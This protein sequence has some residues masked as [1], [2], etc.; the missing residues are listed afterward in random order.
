MT[1]IK[2][3]PSILQGSGQD[4]QG[5]GQ[6]ISSAGSSVLGAATGAPSYDGQFGPKVAAIGQEAYSRL[7]NSSDQLDNL[8]SRLSLKGAEFQA[9]DMEGESGFAG[10]YPLQLQGEIGGVLTNAA[11]GLN[12]ATS[13]AATRF[14]DVGGVLTDAGQIAWETNLAGQ[15]IS[16]APYLNT[17]AQTAGQ[18][19]LLEEAVKDTITSES[20]SVAIP[21]G[22]LGNLLDWGKDYFEYRD[23]GATMVASA[24]GVDTSISVVGEVGGSMIGGLIGGAIGTF[25]LPVPG[26]GTVAGE[27]LGQ[28]IGGAVGPMA[29]KWAM[30]NIH[31]S[32]AGNESLHDLAIKGVSSVLTVTPVQ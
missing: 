13:E 16:V 26:V 12:A 15:W 21:L 4:I 31:I 11:S 28:E 32:S 25:L 5:N 2:V 24:I 19:T 29:A 18:E 17:I 30:D 7:G 1:L 23:Q 6:N 10:G 22:G 20:E 27:A 8:G 3:D 9:V 14:L